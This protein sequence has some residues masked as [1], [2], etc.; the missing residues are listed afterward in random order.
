MTCSEASRIPLDPVAASSA[1]G[2]VRSE[3]SHGLGGV[4]PSICRLIGGDDMTGPQARQLAA[5]LIVAADMWD[6]LTR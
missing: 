3:H 1:S 5:A 4:R 6:T 2:A